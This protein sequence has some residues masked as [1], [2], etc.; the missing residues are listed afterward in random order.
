MRWVDFGKIP[1]TNPADLLLPSTGQWGKIIQ[2][3]S[4]IEIK[5]GIKDRK[6]AGQLPPY[7][8]HPDLGKIN[9]MYCPYYRIQ[10]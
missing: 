1:D 5:T 3:N 10:W 4:Q 6:I 2:K 7:T 9:L 8:N